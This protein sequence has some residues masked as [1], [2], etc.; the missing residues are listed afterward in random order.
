MR[1]GER[2]AAYSSMTFTVHAAKALPDSGLQRFSS[3]G[4]RVPVEHWVIHPTPYGDQ[5][6]RTRGAWAVV[7]AEAVEVV[8]VDGQVKVAQFAGYA[9]EHDAGFEAA[10]EAPRAE[11]RRRGRRGVVLVDV[12]A[13]EVERR[14]GP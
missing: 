11:G 3:G 4:A 10:Q 8:G 14:P 7:E 1:C 6:E 13:V 2:Q 9:V 12:G 5:A